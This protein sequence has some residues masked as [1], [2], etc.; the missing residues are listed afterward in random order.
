M[1]E[2]PD[3]Q[4]EV[5]FAALQEWFVRQQ[6]HLA[7]CLNTPVLLSGTWQAAGSD[8]SFR[9]YFRW[10]AGD[11]RLVLMDAPP[12]EDCR[13]FV[14]MAHMLAV[15]GLQVPR[16]LAQDVKQG[17][18][19]LTDL[20][21]QTWL[22][23]WQEQGVEPDF[24]Q[25]L[26]LL[27]RLQQLNVA[28]SSLP[29]YDVALLRRELDLFPDWYV[30][31]ELGM[32]LT[33]CQLDWWQE[34]CALLIEAAQS[35][36]RVLVHRDYML[37]N[38]MCSGAQPGLLDFQDAVVGPISY[39]VISL[40]KDA[41]VSWPDEQVHVGLQQY[42]RQAQAAGLPV[43]ASFAEFIRDCDWMGLQRHL[44]VIGIFARICHRDGKPSY[45]RDVPRFFAY[46]RPLLAR[47]PELRPLRLLL[48][49]LPLPEN[50]R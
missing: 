47:Y 34:A 40:F 15:A 35:Q 1:S 48:E 5:R 22:Q 50:C 7:A 45:V 21:D 16:V 2:S 11:V 31:H 6:P 44:K 18:L 42:W 41:F 4:E 39:D 32:Q 10:R 46:I 9:R 25:A 28:G 30:K 17:F 49:S 13:P 3:P 33:A 27:I 20:G 24:D 36:S 12:P 8:A 43:P 37:R 14:R 23:A 29:D 19:V 26:E 38:L